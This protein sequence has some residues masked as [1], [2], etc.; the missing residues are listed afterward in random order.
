[1]NHDRWTINR[2][3]FLKLS[4]TGFLAALYHRQ[5][6]AAPAAGPQP[7][8]LVLLE[9]SGGN[10]GL[11]TLVPYTDPAYYSA[12][13][14][15]AIPQESVLTL[16][17]SATHG[18]GLHPALVKLRDRYDQNQV[19]IVRGVGH[20]QPDLSHFAM[21]DYWYAG[22]LRGMAHTNQTGWIGRCLDQIAAGSPEIA[23]LSIGWEMGPVMYADQASTA[24]A[25]NPWAASIDIP[26]QLQDAY[27][28]ALSNLSQPG[29]GA[30]STLAAARAG[31]ASGIG[32]GNFLTQFQDDTKARQASYPD[33]DTGRLL[34]F[35]ADV[36]IA[37]S[38]IRAL[39]VSLPMGFDH[40]AN[41]AQQHAEN[42]TQIDAAVDA[43]LNDLAA[44]QLA[45]STLVMTTS[46]FGRRVEENSD[47][48][49]DHG[50]ASCLFLLGT[51]L[52][53]GMHGS[54]PA[55]TELDPNGNLIATTAFTDVLAAVAEHWLGAPGVV[56]SPATPDLFA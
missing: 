13:P 16:H 31:L 18:L 50:T 52:K 38:A 41:Q 27:Q 26:W 9:L 56:A 30:A 6:G 34:K 3:G 8:R 42:F 35:A 48:G 55:L 45:D 5:I 51:S 1:M 36:L 39:H 14:S 2:R 19:A 25:G 12:R 46:E 54:Q 29:T 4:A 40:H 15:L 23:G 7:K 49:T 10:D 28:A 24:A 21:M 32:L 11:N 37:P 47:G 33:S 20:P 17:D 22:H 53:A 44:N 43:F